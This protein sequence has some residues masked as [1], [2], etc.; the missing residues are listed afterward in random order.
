M[1]R[2][3]WDV[4]RESLVAGWEDGSGFRSIYGKL[5]ELVGNM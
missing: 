3:F 5:E 1:K 4:T 2:A